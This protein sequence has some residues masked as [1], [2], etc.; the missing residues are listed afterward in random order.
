MLALMTETLAAKGFVQGKNLEVKFFDAQN[1]MINLNAIAADVVNQG[2]DLI[3][4]PTFPSFQAVAAANRAGK[5]TQVFAVVADPHTAG[6]GI[7]P[8]D[9]MGHPAYLVGV[10][11]PIPAREALRL[12][13]RLSPKLQKV[14]APFNPAEPNS[15]IWTKAAR[16][17]SQSAKFQLLEASVNHSSDVAEAVQS[18]VSR[19]AEAILVCAD[20]TVLGA[21][22]A[23]M[24][25]AAGANIPVFSCMSNVTNFGSIFDVGVDMI[26]H[27]R[28]VGE[29]VAQILSGTS[30]AKIPLRSTTAKRFIVNEE[31]FRRF[32]DR[33]VLPQ[34]VSDLAEIIEK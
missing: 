15:Q 9:P 21:V 20:S 11:I 19:G 16:E 28:E 25:V 13:R 10:P 27:G 2:Y 33:W 8:N 7:K 5:A 1:D 12:A 31:V 26:V 34:E 4:T 24:K 32:Q 14:G 23:V 6:V 22:P 29:L 30:P 18:L 17:T 3:V